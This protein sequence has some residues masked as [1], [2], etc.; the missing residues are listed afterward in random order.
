MNL[1]SSCNKTLTDEFCLLNKLN[2]C[3]GSADN[4]IISTIFGHNWLCLLLYNI[5]VL[6]K[7]F[8]MYVITFTIPVCRVFLLC[9]RHITLKAAAPVKQSLVM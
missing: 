5:H 8:D 6:K 2:V 7:Y 1:L 3:F 9:Q 4:C